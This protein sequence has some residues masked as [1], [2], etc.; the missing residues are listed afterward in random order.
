MKF[1]CDLWILWNYLEFMISCNPYIYIIQKIIIQ[2]NYYFNTLKKNLRTYILT[3]LV[4]PMLYYK[5]KIEIDINNDELWKTMW[6]HMKAIKRVRGVGENIT[7]LINLH[8]LSHYSYLLST[9]S[10]QIQRF[11]YNTFHKFKIFS[12]TT[13]F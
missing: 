13:W 6:K 3:C 12:L 8:F 10:I 2:K 4:M 1:I 11:I 9:I 7:K 5:T